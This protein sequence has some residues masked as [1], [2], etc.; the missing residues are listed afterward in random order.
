MTEPATSSTPAPAAPATTPPA[1]APATTPAATSEG[2]S[3]QVSTI[4]GQTPADGTQQDAST[5]K[6]AGSTPQ[7]Q[8]A[9]PAEIAVK[10]PD[11]VQVDAELLK[12]FQPIA[13]ELGL[14]SEQAQKLV[15][16]VVARQQANV[17]EA[18]SAWVKRV[19]EEWEGQ[20]K[21]DP[22][23][24]GQAFQASTVAADKAFRQFFDEGTR[25]FLVESGYANHP[26]LFK[27]LVRIG[28]AIGEDSRAGASN[29]VP[30]KSG[31][32]AMA[33]QLFPSMA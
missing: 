21:A 33:E 10:I 30:A 31:M 24:G 25:K 13:R 9:P 2:A 15:D 28:K 4:L 27:A 20:I 12:G 23:I 17:Q 22:D 14:K 19:N 1:P 3:M 32:D 11:G 26:G 7:G 29:S 16:L 6:P 8:Q 18:R 5:D